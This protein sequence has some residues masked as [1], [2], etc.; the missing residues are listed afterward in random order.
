MYFRQLR[1]STEDLN[2]NC[3]NYPTEKFKTFADCDR[4]F[5]RR[6]LPENLIPFWNTGEREKFFRTELISFYTTFPK[7]CNEVHK[8]EDPS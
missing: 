6:M 8:W 7:T 3:T 2:S 5:V 1:M 4:D